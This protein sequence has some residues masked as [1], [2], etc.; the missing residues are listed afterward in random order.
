MGIAYDAFHGKRIVLGFPLYWLTVSS[1]EALVAKA[2]EYFA[3]E[4]VLYG[5]VNGDWSVDILDI[6]FLINF[7][8]KSGPP[9]PDLNNGDPDGSCVINI[10][11]AAYLINYLYKGGAEPVEGCVISG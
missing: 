10:L 1:A 4:S 7:L 3:E 11:D 5:D 2:L 6:T 8:Y 9:P